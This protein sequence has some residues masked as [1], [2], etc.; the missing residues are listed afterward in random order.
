MITL[1]KRQH[2]EC[3]FKRERERFRSDLSNQAF[4]ANGPIYTLDESNTL[5]LISIQKAL[6]VIR[7]CVGIGHLC[8]ITVIWM[9]IT[10]MSYRTSTYN[11]YSMHHVGL[12]VF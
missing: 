3:G 8:F 4:Y 2:V 1:Q 7:Q 5:H 12:G 9:G 10:V 11:S 6:T